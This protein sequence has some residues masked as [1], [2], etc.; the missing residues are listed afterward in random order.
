MKTICYKADNFSHNY[1]KHLQKETR[2][3]YWCMASNL[4]ASQILVFN[5]KHPFMCGFICLQNM[6]FIKYRGALIIIVKILIISCVCKTWDSKCLAL[7]A[8]MA[9]ALGI[10]P[11]VGGLSPPQV[12][13][14]SVSKTLTL[15]QE[16]PF[17][18]QINDVARAQLRFQMLTLLNKKL[19]MDSQTWILSC[20]GQCRCYMLWPFQSI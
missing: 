3:F 11:K 19:I 17:M 8:Q 13:T 9:R 2:T 15:S 1:H 20:T 4:K 7:I 12:E 6:Y 10:N 18:W 5:E 14:F 16:H